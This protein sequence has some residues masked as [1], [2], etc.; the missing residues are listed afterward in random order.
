MGGHR[1]AERTA[2]MHRR[3]RESQYA[4]GAVARH[5]RRLLH[6]GVQPSAAELLAIPNDRPASHF[7]QK[8]QTRVRAAGRRQRLSPNRALRVRERRQHVLLVKLSR[9]PAIERDESD[10]DMNV[11]ER[12]EIIRDRIVRNGGIETA[13]ARRGGED[14]PKRDAMLDQYCRATGIVGGQFRQPGGD[15]LPE[16]ILRIRVV[17]PALER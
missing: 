5:R 6:G 9:C 2:S 1:D 16:R 4:Q 15:D 8:R 12:A 13:G 11:K 10:F 3:R 14:I 17:L 7:L